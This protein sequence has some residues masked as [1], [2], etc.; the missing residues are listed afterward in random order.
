MH[1]PAY[2]QRAEVVQQKIHQIQ[3]NEALQKQMTVPM[4]MVDFLP[5]GLIGVFM[6]V[7]ITGFITCDDIYLHS[8]GSIFIQ[9]CI[10]PF[11]KKPLTP[12]QHIRVLRWSIFGV[13]LFA[14]LFSLL[15]SMAD[16]I[17]MY[18]AITY[19]I[20]VS[21]AGSAIIGGLYW[22][23]G[24]TA[25]AYAALSIGSVLAG[26]ILILQQIFDKNLAPGMFS[27]MWT[28]FPILEK[29]RSL[30]DLLKN[31]PD[32]F[33]INGQ[34]GTFI[35]VCSAIVAYV[36][37]SLIQNKK[38]DI[39]KMLHRDEKRDD[40]E[41]KAHPY[42]FIQLLTKLGLTG[43]EFTRG[44]KFLYQ[45]TFWYNLV[46]SLFFIGI[47]LYYLEFGISDRWWIKFWGLKLVY[48]PLTLGL[49]TTPIF[50]IFGI[51]GL[52]R[53]FRRLNAMK[54]DALDDGRVFDH[55]HLQEPAVAKAAA[56]QKKTG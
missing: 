13:A 42:W 25:A 9:D 7:M 15:F 8:W 5:E 52:I 11:R 26:S 53:M 49:I 17:L 3:G 51:R 14:F 34:V 33:P 10:M 28:H 20:F 6:F 24:T 55:I 54:P 21:G 39:S 46:W 37:I 35:A 1:H 44:D 48:I 22:K 27:W 45:I 30:D 23:K 36:A 16:Y 43:R 32:K 2:A 12:E 4:A 41:H 19:A 38:F 29:Y 56:E 40:A 47:S 50:L 31:L 18:F